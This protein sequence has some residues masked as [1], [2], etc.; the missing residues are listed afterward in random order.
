MDPVV[1]WYGLRTVLI[2]SIPFWIFGFVGLVV[3]EGIGLSK[4]QGFRWGFFLGLIGWLILLLI[5][6]NK[7]GKEISTALEFTNTYL[8]D[9]RHSNGIAGLV[10]Y[11]EAPNPE[12]PNREIEKPRKPPADPPNVNGGFLSD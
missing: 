10:S 7:R 3:A 5:G 8:D 12:V 1:Y 9:I 2:L 11:P 6:L 4:W